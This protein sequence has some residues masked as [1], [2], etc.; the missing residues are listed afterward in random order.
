[1]AVASLWDAKAGLALKAGYVRETIDVLKGDHPAGIFGWK[2]A[3]FIEFVDFVF[4]KL[5]LDSRQVLLE[6][7]DALGSNDD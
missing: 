1:M 7:I 5:E 4:C 6:L 2:R 3:Y